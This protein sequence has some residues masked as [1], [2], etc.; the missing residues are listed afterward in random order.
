[1]FY[2]NFCGFRT[3]TALPQTRKE[4]IVSQAYAR[5]DEEDNPGY[6]TSSKTGLKSI[7]HAGLGTQKVLR[8]GVLLIEKNGKLFNAQGAEVK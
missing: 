7:Q 3:F 1:M 8:D 6:F 4:S 5:P 2:P